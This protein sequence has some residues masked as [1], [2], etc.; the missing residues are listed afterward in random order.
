MYLQ[1]LV[2][3]EST[4]DLKVANTKLGSLNTVGDILK[5]FQ[6]KPPKL[7]PSTF[8]NIVRSKLPSNLSIQYS[9][10]VKPKPDHEH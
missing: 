7:A 6:A 4:F 3:C 10:R 8:P 1:I 5:L 9:T 2:S